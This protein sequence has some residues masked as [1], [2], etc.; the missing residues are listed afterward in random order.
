MIYS[1][2]EYQRFALQW[3][4][5]RTIIEGKSGGAFFLDPGL[6]KTSISLAWIK[7]IK[8][9]TLVVAPLRVVYSVWRQEAAKWDQFRD[10]KFSIVH[11]TSTQRMAALSEDADIY[12][13][14]PEGIPW[15]Q[16][17]YLK[18][19]IPF[20]N[21]V[22]DE[23]SKFKTWGAKR[24]KALR[25]LLPQ[26]DKRLALTGTPCPNSLMDLFS[27]VFIVDQGD[28]LGTGITKFKNRWFYRGG[29]GGYKYFP[30]EGAQKNIERLIEP[31]CLTLRAEDHLDLP[32]LVFNDVWVD[33]PPTI[34]K[35]YKQLE[36]EMFLELDQ[37]ELTPVNAGSKYVLCKQV[38]NG[39]VY[40]EAREVEHIHKVKTE[41]TLE[42]MEE[43]QGKPVLIAYQFK[44]DLDRLEGAIPGLPSING[45]TGGEEANNRILRWNRGELQA[46]AVQCQALSHG[47]N[48]Q[49][50]PGRDVIWYGLTDNLEIYLQLNARI[51]RQGVEGQ[52]RIHRILARNTVD[53]AIRERIKTKDMGQ[54]ALL[55]ALNAYRERT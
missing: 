20:D 12:L 34:Q 48:M 3:L 50:G 21:L 22:V 43:L 23:S 35:R 44:H 14:N 11:G 45:Q 42:I 29:F 25:K 30:M 41:A 1:P 55:N 39:G 15:L 40:D 26:F 51:Y 9:K 17:Y 37:G 10:L 4:I 24:T 47:V 5:Q 19:D 8:G 27:Q 36:R 52:V 18:R 53:E 2:H 38:C 6:G 54:L 46:L 13:I 28:T 7:L 31:C 16:N 33:L 32:A 49:A